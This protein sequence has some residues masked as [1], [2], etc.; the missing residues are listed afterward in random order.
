MRKNVM[1]NDYFSFKRFTVRQPRSA[2]K[3]GTDGVV[4][5]AWFDVGGPDVRILDVGTGTGLIALMAA[6]RNSA[7]RIDAVEID[8]PSCLDAEENFEASPWGGRL[9]LFGEPFAA[10]CRRDTEGGYDRIV[11]NPPYFVRSLR[12][13]DEARTAARHADSLPF[14]ELLEGV[15]GL[16]ASEGA[17]SVILPCDAAQEFTL[18]ALCVGLYRSRTLYVRSVPGTEPKRVCME[19]RFGE[20]TETVASLTLL[21][22]D[23]TA[24]EEYRALAGDFYLRM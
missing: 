11:S 14:G 21:N 15:R 5:G 4:L 13:P 22:E 18:A 10:F 8:A 24:G 23:R 17:L 12:S 16:L 20:R 9:R 1:A 19:F 7:A 6:Q 2:M 3:V